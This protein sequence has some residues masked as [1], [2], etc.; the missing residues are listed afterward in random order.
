MVVTLEND[1][2]IDMSFIRVIYS[3]L[4]IQNLFRKEG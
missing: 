4:I 1:K 3:K 2:F